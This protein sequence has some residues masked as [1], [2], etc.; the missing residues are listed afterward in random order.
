MSKQEASARF[1]RADE[2]YPLP[3]F[4]RRLGL[5][6]AAMRTARRQGLRVRQL[7][8][9]RYVLGRDAL[10]FFGSLGTHG[11]TNA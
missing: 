1:V 6:A 7:G 8:R 11:G 2:I 9:T 5:G 3:E 10:E 4:R